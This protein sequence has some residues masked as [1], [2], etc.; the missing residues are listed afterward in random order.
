MN[1]VYE[2]TVLAGDTDIITN[3]QRAGF[4]AYTDDKTITSKM[5]NT[6]IAS[7]ASSENSNDEL[8]IEDEEIPTPQRAGSGWEKI[9]TSR[10]ENL[11]LEQILII[12]Q[13]FILKLQK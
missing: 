8:N 12:L 1:S 9:D 11:I 10:S 4:S 2:G 7:N 5:A 3:I 6:E 13:E